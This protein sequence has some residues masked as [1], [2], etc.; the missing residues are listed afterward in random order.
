MAIRLSAILCGFL[1]GILVFKLS[2]SMFGDARK[3]FWSSVLLI[4][5]PYFWIISLFFTTDS[6]VTLFWIWAMYSFYKAVN[7]WSLYW[8]WTGIAVGLG[9][10]SKYVMVFF[11]PLV[12]VYLFVFDRSHFRNV[13][14][15]LSIL[16]SAI[17]IIPVVYWNYMHDWVT[18][19]HIWALAGGGEGAQALSI[20]DS[21]KQ[22]LE[23][24]GGQFIFWII[25]FPMKIFKGFRDFFTGKLGKN[26]FYIILPVLA[27][28]AFFLLLS[29]FT[30]VE[31]NWTFFALPVI[32]IYIVQINPGQW[33]PYRKRLAAVSVIL[34]LI[35]FVPLSVKFIDL[36]AKL[37]PVK[38]VI[39]WE[40]MTE[41]LR[42]ELS[43]IDKPYQIVADSYHTASLLAFYLPDHPMVHTFT[44]ANRMNQFDLWRN[45]LGVQGEDLLTVFIGKKELDEQDEKKFFGSKLQQTTVMIPFNSTDGKELIVVYYDRFA[46][47]GL[48]MPTSY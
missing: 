37:N 35:M 48:E 25:I 14:L 40:D 33:S 3:A 6:L 44:Q 10:I 32:V 46:A 27:V 30:G 1:V 15:Y 8:I 4:A 24:I 17:F 13:Y 38:R 36:P 28:F 22:L 20:A 16:L 41:E 26:Y 21:G 2:F 29:F 18:I 45:E 12:F 5:F 23:F 31:V 9:L 7:G 47:S 39:G 11:W 43:L 34:I 19:K 42:Q